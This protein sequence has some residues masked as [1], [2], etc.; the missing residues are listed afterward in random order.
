LFVCLLPSSSSL[1]CLLQHLIFRSRKTETNLFQSFSRTA[2]LLKLSY[3]NKPVSATALGPLLQRQGKVWFHVYTQ[4]S[5]LPKKE[6]PVAT[7]YEAGT[8]PQQVRTPCCREKSLAAAVNRIQIPQLSSPI[9][10][11]IPAGYLRS[12]TTMTTTK[13]CNLFPTANN[14]GKCALRKI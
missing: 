3:A 11:T 1:F 5:L 9:L 13:I 2:Y 7:E 4:V 6:L 8:G 12:A 14:N 10:L